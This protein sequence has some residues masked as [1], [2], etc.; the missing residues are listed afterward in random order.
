MRGRLKDQIFLGLKSFNLQHPQRRSFLSSYIFHIF[1]RYENIPTKKFGLVTVSVN[2]KEMGLY[3]YEEIP[4][5]EMYKR[6]YG[7]SYIPI[8]LMMIIL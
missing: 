3:N 2:G 8:F 7:K 4:S 5:K 1:T 6:I